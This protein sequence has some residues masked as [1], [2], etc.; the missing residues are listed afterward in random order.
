MCFIPIKLLDFPFPHESSQPSGVP[1]DGKVSDDEK[2]PPLLL[3]VD[4][5]GVD[6]H[7]KLDTIGME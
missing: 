6:S 2:S 5:C 3:I 4:N 1:Y 7:L